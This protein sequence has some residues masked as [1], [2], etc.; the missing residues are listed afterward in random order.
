M[1]CK[2]GSGGGGNG[3]GKKDLHKFSR[4][5]K[6][7][8]RS[9]DGETGGSFLFTLFYQGN[10]IKMFLLLFSSLNVFLIIQPLH[11][12]KNGPMKILTEKGAL[13]GICPHII[14]IF[15]LLYN[16]PL[17]YYYHRCYYSHVIYTH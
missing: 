5:R 8:D 16:R 12:E 9:T 2:S 17:N 4:E 13:G 1:T 7:K 11:R 15:N 10:D 14:Y 6:E 3:G